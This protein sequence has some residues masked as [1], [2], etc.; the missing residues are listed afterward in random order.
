[1]PPPHINVRC[2][3]LFTY[4]ALNLTNDQVIRKGTGACLRTLP[5]AKATEPSQTSVTLIL[6]GHM[7]RSKKQFIGSR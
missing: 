2:Y 3:S 5:R 4:Q 1:M 7:S 6:C